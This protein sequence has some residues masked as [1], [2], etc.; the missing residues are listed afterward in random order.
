MIDIENR[1]KV[2]CEAVGEEVE[3]IIGGLHLL[4]N[5]LQIA[6]TLQRHHQTTLKSSHISVIYACLLLSTFRT[7]TL[8]T[9]DL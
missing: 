7:F 6:S 4:S 5:P 9:S 8:I 1:Q 2:D 3:A